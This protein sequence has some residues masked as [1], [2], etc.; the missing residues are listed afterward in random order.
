[1]P[2]IGLLM[3]L[4]GDITVDRN[5]RVSGVRALVRAR[6]YLKKNVS[7]MFFPEGTRS[8]DGR[9]YAFNDGAFGL[10]IREQ[11]PVLPI[12]IDGSQNA[13]PRGGWRFG[14]AHVRVQVLAP[15]PTE[16][17]TIQNLAELR[18]R[19]R[20]LLAQQLATWRCQPVTMVDAWLPDECG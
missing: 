18:D 11:V 8:P 5:S 12:A 16:G 6:D 19:V 20:S 4:V 15:V 7:V 14:N 13:L 9:L 1:M 3:R 17:L 10:A 2:L